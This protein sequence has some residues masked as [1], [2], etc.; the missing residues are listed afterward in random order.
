MRN[1]NF[2]VSDALVKGKGLQVL[3]KILC[4]TTGHDQICDLHVESGYFSDGEARLSAA[5]GFAIFGFRFL[6][7]ARAS[8]R[9]ESLAMLE[10]LLDMSLDGVRNTNWFAE[11]RRGF[12]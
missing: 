6:A 1:T 9:I 12:A 11:S 8:D 5:A 2:I 10:D 3:V 4:Q 7:R